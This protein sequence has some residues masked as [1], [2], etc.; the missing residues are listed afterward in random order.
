[1]IV[2]LLKR[3]LQSKCEQHWIAYE[4]EDEAYTSKCS[5]LDGEEVK[6]HA[7]YLGKRI[8][9][10]M[11]RSSNGTQINADVNSAANIYAKH[12][13]N[14]LFGAGSGMLS[15]PARVCV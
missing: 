15:I 4:V 3:K 6:K 12:T 10:G 8:H 5:Y 2:D 7:I 9:R 1:M 13:G 11:F 14:R